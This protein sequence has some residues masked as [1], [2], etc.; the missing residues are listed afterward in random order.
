MGEF[1]IKVEM[2][3]V[4]AKL[5]IMGDTSNNIILYIDN[6]IL[7]YARGENIENCTL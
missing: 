6:I 3:E 2:I 1:T 5:A 4:L 7:Y